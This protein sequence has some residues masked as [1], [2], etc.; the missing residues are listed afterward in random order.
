[1]REVRRRAHPWLA[2]AQKPTSTD[3]T[4][5]YMQQYHLNALERGRCNCCGEGDE[6]TKATL[7][8]VYSV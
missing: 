3:A 2:P 6:S 8:Y 1:M 7:L 4:D 5:K